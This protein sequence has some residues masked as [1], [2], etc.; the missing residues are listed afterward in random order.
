MTAGV[1]SRMAFANELTVGERL[2]WAGQRLEPDA[3]LYNMALAF[4]VSGPL[5]V[6]AFAE[7]FGQLVAGTDALRTVFVEEHGEPR[8]RVLDAV[9]ARVELLQLPT[10][11]YVI[12]TEDTLLL[13]SEEE[14]LERFF[15]SLER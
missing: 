7:A 13:V 9:D 15:A 3:P 2:I 5:D 4:D 8:R 6:A 14:S 12:N 1:S 11:D 10:A